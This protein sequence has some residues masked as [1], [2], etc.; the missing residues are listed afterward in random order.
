MGGHVQE[1]HACAVNQ[2]QTENAPPNSPPSS[3]DEGTDTRRGQ[4]GEI[5]VLKGLED[6]A[7][8]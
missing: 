8:F 5:T 1:P 7:G 3:A 2:I 6:T 4:R